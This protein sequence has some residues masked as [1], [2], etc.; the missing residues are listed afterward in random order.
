MTREWE[1]LT[2]RQVA[3]LIETLLRGDLFNEVAAVICARS[4]SMR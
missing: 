4:C 3:Q 2:E 1:W